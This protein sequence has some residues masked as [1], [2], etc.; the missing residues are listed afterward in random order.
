MVGHVERMHEYCM[1]RRLFMVDVSGD[2]YGVD[3]G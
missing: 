1:G 2:G 3:R